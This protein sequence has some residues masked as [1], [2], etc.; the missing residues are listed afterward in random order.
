MALVTTTEMF[1][2]AYTGGYAVG[3]FNDWGLILKETGKFIG[4]CGYTSFDYENNTAEIGYVLS[5]DYWGMGLAAEAAKKGM[6]VGFDI[7]GL[8]GYCAKCI[9]GNDAA[10]RVRQKEF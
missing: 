2:K 6:E 1:K 7:F 3:A 5:K 10:M 9:E 4:T 8:D